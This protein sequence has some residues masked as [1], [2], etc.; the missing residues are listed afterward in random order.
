MKI[1]LI[2]LIQIVAIAG[3]SA[4]K[5]KVAEKNE[6]LGG[7]K[8]NALYV[9]VYETDEKLIE[10]EWKSLLK[11]YNAKMAT[12]G[13]E[14]FGDN[15]VIKDISNNTIDIYWKL[16]KGTEN[17]VRVIA[18]FDLGG[19]YLSSGT[20]GKEYRVIETIMYD[21]AL[22]LTR[23]TVANQLKEAQKEAE[24]RDKKLKGLVKDN[25]DL[26][27]DIDNYKAKIQAAENN[28][29]LNLNDQKDAKAA[30]DAQNKIL[31]DAKLRAKKYE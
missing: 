24:K 2:A 5:I 19:A 26:H 9:P 23:K 8:H 12:L 28:I 14:Q 4:Q 29:S 17:S 11:R 10:K 1:F 6:N 15:A 31:E 30:L 21:F 13:D 3:V 20:H 22:E 16:E 25:E 27:K 18:A 7:G